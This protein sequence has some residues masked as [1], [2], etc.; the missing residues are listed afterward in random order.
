VNPS[1]S[2]SVD[3]GRGARPF[4]E[5]SLYSYRC[6]SISLVLPVLALWASPRVRLL[7]RVSSGG[8]GFDATS[9]DRCRR[10]LTLRLDEGCSMLCS[11]S[12]GCVRFV[13]SSSSTFG[14]DP[15][16]SGL[17]SLMS[18]MAA[19]VCCFPCQIDSGRWSF[20]ELSA[21]WGAHG[22]KCCGDSKAWCCI[23]VFAGGFSSDFIARCLSGLGWSCGVRRR[24]PVLSSD[25]GSGCFVIFLFSK[26]FLI[27]RVCIVLPR[28]IWILFR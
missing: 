24:S 21:L 28:A 14:R 22:I 12:T 10:L 19:P 17:S 3:A 1:S 23:F 13:W 7:L 6:S 18:R 11:A 25:L 16:A 20:N 5:R 27:K 2:R 8:G 9:G 15:F 26:V 4:G